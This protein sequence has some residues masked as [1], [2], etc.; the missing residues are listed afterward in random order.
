MAEP[1]NPK[2]LL[3][4]ALALVSPRIA[5]RIVVRWRSGPDRE[6]PLS[7]FHGPTAG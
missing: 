1:A 6:E 2:T 3:A 5:R 4:W 7:P